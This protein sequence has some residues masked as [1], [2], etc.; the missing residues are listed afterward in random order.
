[1]VWGMARK[2]VLIDDFDGSELP[3]DTKP[4]HI[5]INEK[6]YRLHLSEKSL[7]ALNE[8]LAPFVENAEQDT[9]KN[10]PRKPTN[11]RARVKAIREWA[12]KNNI[13]FN[14][15]PLGDRGRIPEDIVEQ[16]EAAH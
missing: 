15:K 16:Y 2:I 9:Q 1:M 7:K 12:Q 4:T 13:Q 8:A 14:G 10:A 3:S 5:T 6:G 11:D